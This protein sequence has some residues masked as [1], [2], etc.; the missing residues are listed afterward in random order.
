MINWSKM[1]CRQGQAA[2]KLWINLATEMF[3]SFRVYCK[4]S[5]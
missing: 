4:Y 1:R 3:C 2:W 5:W